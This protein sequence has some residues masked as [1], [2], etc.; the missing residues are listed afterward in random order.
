MQRIVGLDGL[1]DTQSQMGSKV[2]SS[3][4][5][6]DKGKITIYVRSKRVYVDTKLLSVPSFSGGGIWSALAYQSTRV[7]VCE[8]ILD[9]KQREEL[10]NYK[11]LAR[12]LGVKL[13]IKD[14][15]KSNVFTR[16]LNFIVGSKVPSNIPSVSVSGDAVYLLRKN[17]Q[18]QDHEEEGEKK[19]EYLADLC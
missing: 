19:E 18:R 6:S 7:T 10:E 1:I 16:F 9:E 2:Q 15:G 13:E 12:S 5:T 3:R 17:L 8:D 11:A 14:I 4:V